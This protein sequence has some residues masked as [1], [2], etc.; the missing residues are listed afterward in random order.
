MNIS[1]AEAIRRYDVSKPTLYSDMKDGKLSFTVDDRKRRK[2]NIAELERLYEQRKGDN[3]NPSEKSVKKSSANTESNVKGT[4]YE[5]GQLEKEV[6]Y[7]KREVQ[8]RQQETERWQEAFDKAQ[9]TADKITTLLEDHRT[10]KKDDGAGEWDKSLKALESRIAN[11]EATAKEEK[12]R[13]DKILR[14]N[15]ALKKALDEEKSKGFFKKLFG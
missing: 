9:S 2:I 11:Q 13:A 6:E 3:D 5:V 1:P 12:E 4:S 10:S 14:Q 7:L 15:R 8:N